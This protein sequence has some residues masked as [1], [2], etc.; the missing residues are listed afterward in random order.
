MS[1][2]LVEPPPHNC[3]GT[4]SDNAGKTSAC[5]GC[6]NQKVTSSTVDLPH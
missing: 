5:E 1:E 2:G 6:P 3:P 4:E